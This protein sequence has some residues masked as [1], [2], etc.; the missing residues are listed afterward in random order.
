M[1]DRQREHSLSFGCICARALEGVMRAPQ[2]APHMVFDFSLALRR[3]AAF[4]GGLVLLFFPFAIIWAQEGGGAHGLI[5][6]TTDVV[7]QSIVGVIVLSVFLLLAKETAHRVLI[8]MCAVSILFIVTYAT[9][10]HLITFEGVKDAL[11]INVLMLLAAMMAVV[12]VLKTTGVFEW[13]VGKLMRRAGGRPLVLVAL[14]LWFTAIASAM[15]DNVTTVVFVTPMVLAVARQ[16]G[17]NPVALLLPMIMASNIGGTATL[18]GD[19]P[20]IMI[21]SGAGISFIDFIEVL[22]VP[23]ATM[24]LWLEYYSRRYYGKAYAEAAAKETAE[25][26]IVPLEDP[27]LAKWLGV[28]CVGI[29]IG[30]LTHHITGTPA[31]VP[32]LIG[33][34]AALIVQDVLYIK[35]HKPTIHERMHG[36]LRVT[37]EDIEWPTLAFFGFLFIAVGAAV[38]TG[39]IGSLADGLRWAVLSGGEAMSLSPNGVLLFGAILICWVS[40]LASA[41]VDNIP[42]VA[43]AIPVIARILPELQGNV[44][45]MWWALSFGACLGG[46]GSVIGAS[47]NL[48]TIGIAERTGIQVTFGMFSR[49]ATPMTV[50]T[51]L[52]ATVYLAM[53]IYMGKIGSLVASAAIFAVLLALRLLRGGAPAP[54]PS[55][56]S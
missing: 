40:G 52:M 32:A 35:R 31:A 15:L 44:E 18:I 34:A 37:E 46:N 50:V 16:A 9:P 2:L 19:P 3:L 53:F 14:I 33:A 27:R 55:L 22:A 21:G 56:N 7:S 10:Y 42:F 54:A 17:I 24:M 20:N 29:L 39:L 12:G 8:V 38:N 11:D 5:E 36:I 23:C 49:Y 47:A 41:L 4:A 45:V 13:A 48:T 6:P 1:I 43:V 51:L 25:V 30:F 26:P 28:I